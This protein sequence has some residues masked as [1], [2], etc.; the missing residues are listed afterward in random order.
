VAELQEEWR[1][2]TPVARVTGEVDASNIGDLGVRLR[3]LAGN[4]VPGLVVDLT[5]TTYLDSAGINLLFAVG[6][7]LAMRRQTLRVVMDEHSPV[8]RMLRITGLERAHPTHH[9]VEEALAA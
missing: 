4:E 6:E 8:A 3:L 1:D 5:G 9:S 7:E 2:G